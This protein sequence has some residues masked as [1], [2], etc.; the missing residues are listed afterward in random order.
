MKKPEERKVFKVL[1]SVMK[2]PL[3]G[4]H[5]KINGDLLRISH[6]MDHGTE[7]YIL[8]AYTIPEFD[9]EDVTGEY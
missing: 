3:T 4:S 2:H 1:K 7:N 6:T 5:I 9:F 8:V